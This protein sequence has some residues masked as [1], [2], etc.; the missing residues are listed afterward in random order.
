MTMVNWQKKKRNEIVCVW[1]EIFR[2]LCCYYLIW[3]CK[4]VVFP[5]SCNRD[6]RLGAGKVLLFVF[7]FVSSQIF[8]QLI[9]HWTN[10]AKY[11][12]IDKHSNT[13]ETLHCYWRWQW[14]KSVNF[15]FVLCINRK[16]VFETLKIFDSRIT[17]YNCYWPD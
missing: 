9:I 11:R 5:V 16:L 3:K 14:R 4:Y 2:Q 10:V 1:P 8:S 7:F 15:N 6:R 13:L 17:H 12:T